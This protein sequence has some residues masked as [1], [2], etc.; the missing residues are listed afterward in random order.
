MHGLAVYPRLSL[1][2]TYFEVQYPGLGRSRP[3][4]LAPVPCDPF[5]RR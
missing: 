5:P 2:F 4:E 3:V 1:A